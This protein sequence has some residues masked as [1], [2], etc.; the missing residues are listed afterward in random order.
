MSRPTTRADLKAIARRAM[1]ERGLLPDFSPAAL[2]ELRALDGHA[3]EDPMVTRDLRDRP[4]CSIDN[5][6]S[7][8][9]DQLS[10]SEPVPGGATRILVAVADV[11][12]MVKPG[13][14]IDSHA[15]TNTTTVYT[16]AEIFS[17]LPERLSTDLT[18]LGQ[19]EERLA[20]VVDM[21]V[22]ADG[23]VG[24]SDIYRARVTNHAKLT[25][26]AVA[27]WLEGDGPAPAAV[28]SVPGLDAQLRVQDRIA[29]ALKG[30]RH[31]RGALS[32]ETIEANV[33]F[34]GDVLT[35]LKP[36]AKNR[37]KELIEDFMI[38][39]NSATAAYLERKGFPSLRRVLRAPERW[40]R[41]VQ[42]AATFAAVLPDQPDA[43]ALEQFLVSR[44]A[45][46]PT[47]FADLSLSIVKMLG[48]GEYV[49]ELPGAASAGHFGLAVKDY[50]HSTAP[51]RRFPDLATQRLLKA[52]LSG[53]PP[54]YSRDEL[55]QLAQQCTAQS[56]G[57]AKVERQ[58]RKSA[59]ALLLQSRIGE[60]FKAVVTGASDKGTYV[61]IFQPAV[62]GRV[63]DGFKGLD[64][65][66]SVTVQLLRT[67]VE[68]GFIDFRV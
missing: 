62:E 63:V 29:Q 67:D 53:A 44:R 68:R 27:A 14:A 32:L 15:R 2:A 57:A 50:T 1:L 60:R 17:M 30:C 21:E 56:N 54:P 51:N 23:V 10:V 31:D 46:D 38:A 40:E 26:D 4:W 6:S 7:R 9:L 66:D 65:G 16:A 25:Y 13:S 19:G 22:A 45:A 12:A 41:I 58:V 18:S 61:R 39:A 36:D 64:V 42:F 28:T 8:D 47:R 11:D 20:I 59:A 43:R 37:A 49:V 3:A 52:A 33:V 24:T 35:D 48:S 5:D 55:A 34:D